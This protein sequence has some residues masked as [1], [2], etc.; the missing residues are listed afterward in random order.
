[1]FYGQQDGVLASQLLVL[2]PGRYRLSTNAPNAPEGASTLRWTLVCAR[3]SSTIASVPLDQAIAGTWQFQVPPSCAAQ[4]LELFGT[5]SDVARQT[6]LTIRS[7][8]L[9]REPAG[10]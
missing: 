3:D 4:R 6:D 7:I 10:A 9:T 5:S 1:M 2:P 8:E